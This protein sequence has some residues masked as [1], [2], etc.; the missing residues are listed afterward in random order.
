MIET[1]KTSEVAKIIGIHPNTVRLYEDLKLIPKPER[2][3][4]GYRIFTKVHIEHF[5]LVRTALQVEVLQNGLRKQVVKVIKVAALKE[6]SK[7]IEL[8]EKYIESIKY[9]KNQAEEAISIVAGILADNNQEESPTQLTRKEAAEYL[10]ITMD[11]LRNWELNGLITIKRRSNSY[12]VYRD[13]DMKILK[14]IR[15]LRCANYSLNSILRLLKELSQGKKVDIKEVINTPKLEEDIV[16]ICDKL[17]T[18]LQAAEVN[19]K[20]IHGQL[21]EMQIEYFKNPPL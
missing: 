3:A 4:N 14:I 17:L 11:T 12:R 15:V 2:L 18:S 10:N 19:A 9:E 1:Y 7:A 5:K 8:T 20:V 13:S 16:S 21:K 6:Y